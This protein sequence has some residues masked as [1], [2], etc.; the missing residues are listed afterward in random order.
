MKAKYGFGEVFLTPSCTASLE[1]GAVLANLGEGDEVIVP[2]YTFSSTVNAIVLFGAKPIFCEVDPLTM[3]IDVNKIEELIT[4]KT[5]IAIVKGSPK[6]AAD[7]A[8][9]FSIMRTNPISR[10]CV[11]AGYSCEA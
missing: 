11:A 4:P 3:N 5:K 2:S 8:R 10:T 7:P 6:R 9:K 1:M